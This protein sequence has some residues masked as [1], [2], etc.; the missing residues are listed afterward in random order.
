[1][2]IKRVEHVAI[3]VHDMQASKRMLEETFGLKVELEEQI[4]HHADLGGY[5][6]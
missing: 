3:A 5:A 4:G 2:K 1:M 6:P